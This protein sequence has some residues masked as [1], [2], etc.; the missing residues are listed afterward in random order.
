[1]FFDRGGVLRVAWYG[2][3]LPTRDFPTY[4][5]WYEQGKLDLDRVV[6]RVVSLE[7]S[8]EAFH[9]MERGETL[10]TVIRL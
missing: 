3:I 1:Q 7:E 6:T 10:R 5:T 4:A 8:E 9:A 2:D